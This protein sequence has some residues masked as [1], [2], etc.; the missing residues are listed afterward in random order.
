M[1]LG[2][3]RVASIGIARRVLLSD[4]ASVL[5]M[6]LRREGVGDGR[7]EA[8]S[9]H[10]LGGSGGGGAGQVADGIVADCQIRAN[11]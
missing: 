5:I 7:G 10:I 3:G 6:G 8:L 1:K 11:R 9:M 4:R 2:V